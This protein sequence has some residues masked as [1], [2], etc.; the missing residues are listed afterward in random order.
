MLEGRRAGRVGSAHGAA[1]WN[2]SMFGIDDAGIR[3]L[4]SCGAARD[5]TRT[6]T[7][8]SLNGACTLLQPAGA[9][10]SQQTSVFCGATPAC[11]AAAGPGAALPAQQPAEQPAGAP[12]QQPW[13][14]PQ[15]PPAQAATPHR[16]H[17]ELESA[18][19]H[20]FLAALNRKVFCLQPV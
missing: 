18:N 10:A 7:S 4:P 20:S 6:S 1:K 16:L 19:S 11:A 2:S 8:G 3:V 14:P 9:M 12:Q 5:Q 17:C 15:R 13:P